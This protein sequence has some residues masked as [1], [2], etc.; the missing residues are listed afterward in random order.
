MF[1]LKGLR[2]LKKMLKDK[3]TDNAQSERI[4]SFKIFDI[5]L[6]TFNL[7][8]I[9]LSLL[10]IKDLIESQN[11]HKVLNILSLLVIIFCGLSTAILMYTYIEDQQRL[12]KQEDAKKNTYSK[13]IS[14]EEWAFLLCIAGFIMGFI[15]IIILM[16]NIE[17]KKTDKITKYK[18]EININNDK[19]ITESIHLSQ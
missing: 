10:F 4:E 12:L 2:V 19:I 7:G 15:T 1:I 5:Q 16:L 17:D 6:F 11:S 8:L 14:L 9:T 18:I 3:T 13:I